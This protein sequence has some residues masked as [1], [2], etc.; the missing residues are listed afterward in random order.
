MHN[1]F[2]QF[3][4]EAT[5]PHINHVEDSILDY[6][7]EGALDS[8]NH[9][10][11]VIHTLEGHGKS[12]VEVTTKYD[13]APAIAA[14]VNPENGKFFVGTKA[15]FSKSNPKICYTQQDV[16]NYYGDLEDLS[17]KLKLALQYLPELNIKGILFGD[18]MFTHISLKRH[19]YE[20]EQYVTFTPNTITYAVPEGSV[21]AGRI[22]R[23]KIGIIFHTSYT[24]QTLSNLSPSFKI[25]INQLKQTPNVWFDDAS[26]KD[27]S[28]KAMLSK[29][30]VERV[31]KHINDA[32]RLLNNIDRSQLGSFMKKATM[33]NLVKMHLNQEVRK[34][35]HIN[36]PHEHAE[37]LVNFIHDRIEKEKK[38]NPDFQD[39]AER[40]RGRH[41][42][43]VEDL[44]PFL[45]KVFEFQFLL[46][47]AKL[48][49]IKKLESTSH[50]STFMLDD[51]GLKVAGHEGFV[52]VD[53]LSGK[54]V[55]LVDRINFSRQ[56]FARQK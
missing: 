10:R 6:G 53:H 45:I 4:T 51:E 40:K 44:E 22:L 28:G 23:A 19:T 24:G 54:A 39:A 18:L 34:G 21:L 17:T 27:I 31:S 42:K 20:G 32:L 13:G 36:N 29:Q 49:L 25:N 11:H 30:D 35:K 16:D 50:I 14:G 37:E 3:L 55:K 33:K 26:Y 43:Q 47:E 12:N 7:Y 2:K 8:I 38:K 9:L 56:N 5:N 15:V 46:N 1:T 41:V 52:A 48:I